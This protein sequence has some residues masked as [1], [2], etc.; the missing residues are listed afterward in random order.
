MIHEAYMPVYRCPDFHCV[1]RTGS[2]EV[3]QEALADL[4][5]ISITPTL[6]NSPSPIVSSKM[7]RFLG[8]S[9]FWSTFRDISVGGQKCCGKSI[10]LHLKCH[11]VFQQV[12]RTPV[13]RFTYIE[14]VSNLKLKL[15]QFETQMLKLTQA[16]K[17]RFPLL[18]W[19]RQ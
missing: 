19:S 8:N 18:H 10:V 1:V 14:K 17:T 13:I 9:S 5:T 6:P 16:S 3:V 15:N 2:P 4:K 7:S 11:C 12:A